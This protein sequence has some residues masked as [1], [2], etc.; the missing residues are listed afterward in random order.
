[1]MKVLAGCI[2]PH[3]D[4]KN[5]NVE[6]SH[7]DSMFSIRATNGAQFVKMSTPMLGEDSE[8]FCVDGRML[9][10][11][12]SRAS[13]MIDISSDGKVC[14]IKGNGRT[15]MPVMDVE[16][17]TPR[18]VTGKTVTVASSY[19]TNA[20]SKV[21]HAVS[22][23]QSRIILT[24]VCIEVSNNEMKLIAI[25]GFQMSVETI[26]CEGDDIKFVVPCEL[27]KKVCDCAS[28]D[29]DIS[30]VTDGSRLYARTDTAEVSGGLLSGEFI[31]WRRLIPESFKTEVLFTTEEFSNVLKGS[32]VVG[33]SNHLVKL[34]ITNNELTVTSNSDQTGAEFEGSI[35]INKTG[36][37]QLIAFNDKYL[38]NAFNTLTGEESVMKLN[39][40]VSPVIFTTKGGNDIRLVLPVRIAAG[41]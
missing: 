36:E 11:I 1:M 8:V 25:D 31:D 24:G 12:V 30:L 34:I 32:S 13:G 26:P 9:Y 17:G 10:N 37:N 18:E 21:R 15:R 28:P 4:Q 35:S 23:D 2:D 40:S 41:G 22:V 39:S 14:S 3:R 33:N 19:F 7:K 5:S 27:M 29:E 6:I 38:V 16:L 20:F